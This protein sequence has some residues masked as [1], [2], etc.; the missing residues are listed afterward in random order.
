M[1]CPLTFSIDKKP[2]GLIGIYA[3]WCCIKRDFAPL[4]SLIDIPRHWSWVEEHAL[5]DATPA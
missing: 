4:G 5:A 3:T 1:V 2:I